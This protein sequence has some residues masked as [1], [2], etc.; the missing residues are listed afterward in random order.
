MIIRCPSCSTTYKVDSSV[1]DAP[2]PSFRCS[3]CKHIFAV[4][5]RLQLENGDPPAAPAATDRMAESAARGEPDRSDG[6]DAGGALDSAGGPDTGGEPYPQGLADTRNSHASGVASTP[7]HTETPQATPELPRTPADVETA[8]RDADET[9]AAGDDSGETRFE[10]PDFDPFAEADRPDVQ[11]PE[12]LEQTAVEAPIPARTA[13]KPDFEIDDDFLIPPRREAEPPK[14][15]RPNTRGSIVPLVS[16]VALALF[17]F[18]LVT[19]IYQVNP[20]PLNSVLRRIPWYGSTLFEDRH[21]KRTLV[22]ESLVSGVQPV[23]NQTE[24]FVVS[25]KLINRN[26]RSI[27]KVQIE[28]RLF[29]AEGKQVGRQVTFVGNAIS[30]KI[31]QDMTFR[32]ISLLQSLKPQSAYRIPANESANFT[33]VFPKPKSSVE[34]FT[35]R[36]VSADAAA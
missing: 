1:L 19:V 23:L 9:R 12:S 30:A 31:I 13:R 29:D 36:V 26:D 10:Y 22:F 20:Q 17:G 35:C 24:V 33:I 32:E 11:Q 14:P 34:S 27:H 15:P 8:N 5:I 25:G 2:R 3:R 28:A 4:Q 21:F 18:G 6:P 7:S 16:L